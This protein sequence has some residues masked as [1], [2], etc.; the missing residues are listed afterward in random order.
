MIAQNLTALDL[1]RGEGVDT[2][3]EVLGADVTSQTAV[4]VTKPGGTISTIGYYGD[5]AFVR[6][7]CAEWGVGMA[8]KWIATGLCPGD[9]LRM[10]RLAAGARST[11]CRPLA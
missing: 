11:A 9:K 2:A 7:P 3:I 8:D 4:K 10:E 5:G 6:I 1:T